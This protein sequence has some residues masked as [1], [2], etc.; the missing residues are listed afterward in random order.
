VAVLNSLETTVS[1]KI[2]R[3]LHSEAQ[4]FRLVRMGN[5]KNIKYLFGNGLASP[6][7]IHGNFGWSLLAV[8]RF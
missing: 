3:V 8:G 4:V 1:L 5:I 6:N 7:D 2:P